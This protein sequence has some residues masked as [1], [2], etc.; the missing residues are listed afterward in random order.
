MVSLGEALGVDLKNKLESMVNPDFV[1]PD[2]SPEGINSDN[3]IEMK[4]E[5]L[6][7]IVRVT[8]R[9]LAFGGSKHNY[10]IFANGVSTVKGWVAPTERNKSFVMGYNINGTSVRTPFIV[11][12]PRSH[13][14]L[15][16]KYCRQNPRYKEVTDIKGKVQLIEPRKAILM[17]IPGVN[18]AILDYYMEAGSKLPYHE[19]V[20]DY[21]INSVDTPRSIEVSL[22]N[23]PIPI[24]GASEWIPDVIRELHHTTTPASGPDPVRNPKGFDN[25][26]K[27]ETTV[28]E[29]ESRFSLM[30]DIGIY[31]KKN[32]NTTGKITQSVMVDGVRYVICPLIYSGYTN[33]VFYNEV[34]SWGAIV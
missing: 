18:A 32:R 7:Q 3:W 12:N 9:A 10:F 19:F 24:I 29:I 28:T 4:T 8:H 2:F 13:R 11:M 6:Q 33:D 1:M 26:L 16:D 15:H 14:A 34:E 27:S 5:H 30:Q 31:K 17:G 20:R 25:W 22:T 23:S 21:N